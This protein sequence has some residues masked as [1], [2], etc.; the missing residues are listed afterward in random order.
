MKSRDAEEGRIPAR[1]EGRIRACEG[2]LSSRLGKGPVGAGKRALTKLR[3]ERGLRWMAWGAGIVA[4]GVLIGITVF[5]SFDESG[6]G[7]TIPPP[8]ES[9]RIEQPQGPERPESPRKDPSAAHPEE[10]GPESKPVR[11]PKRRVSL[12]REPSPTP[13]GAEEGTKPAVERATRGK[14]GETPTE[15]PSLPQ[16]RG[17]EERERSTRAAIAQLVQVEGQVFVVV[18]TERKVAGD[19]H[20]L[21]AGEG[22]RT[23]GKESK[24]VLK[25]PDG[26]TVVVG[27]ETI[28][29]EIKSKGGKRI[30]IDQGMITA[31][32]VKQ[33]S[34]RPMVFATAQGE[35]TV[36]GTSLRILVDLPDAKR[37]RTR[38]EVREGRVKL[39]RTSDGKVLLVVSGYYAVAA[40]GVPLRARLLVVT[41]N[42]QDGAAPAPGYK[43]TRDTLISKGAQTQN[44]GNG[45]SLES[46]GDVSGFLKWDLSGIPRGSAIRTASITLS[47]TLRAPRSEFRLYEAKRPWVETEAT[48]KVYA[49][50]RRWGADGTR[51]PGDRGSVPVGTLIPR[52][53]GTCVVRL[54][55]AG[56]ALVQSWIRS[57]A[58]NNGLMI[59]GRANANPFIFESREA[60]SVNRR[61]QLTLTYTMV[62]R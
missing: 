15:K 19:G 50:G 23:V 57:P 35:A 9:A 10:R 29:P 14:V 31:D 37:G 20:R 6:P 5:M 36:L 28:V 49:K 42:F 45:N 48:W 16:P 61:P 33:H 17:E 25:F 46:S 40:A 59:V 32:V 38:L 1:L 39:K 13:R 43:G 44:F 54:N 47:V 8:Q 27:P 18:G 34:G 41:R 58:T 30:R 24:A 53:M 22:L 12:P 4:A 26:T 21:L 7:R 51:A 3:R 60:S 62:T 55:P 56:I 11:Q 52:E 2:I